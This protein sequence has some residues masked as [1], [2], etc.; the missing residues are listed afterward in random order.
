MNISKKD[1]LEWFKYLSSLSG[2]K[3]MVYTRFSMIIESTIRQIELAVNKKHSELKKEI[4]NLQTLKE[5]TFFV[6]KKSM[7]PK[8]CISCLFGNGLGGIRKTNR[9]N[10]TC[11]FCYYYDTLDEQE[12]IPDD[13]WEI[14]ENLYYEDDI[15]L[16]LSIQKNPKGVAYVYLE[17]FLEI[18][19]YYNIIKKF[20]KAGIYQHMYTNG[21]LCTEENLKKLGEAGLDELRFNL[22]AVNC[23][24]KV[25]E[26]M[27]IAKKYIAMVGI[28]TPMTN[29]FFEK[30]Q[31]KMDKIL[32]SGIDF[33]NCAELH[34]GQDN[35]NNYVGEKMY[36]SRR[37]YISPI[38]SRENTLKL[39]KIAES[40]KWNIVIH[41][42]SNHTKYCR[43]LNKASKQNQVFGST[44]YVSEFDRFLPHL[45]L[46]ILEDIDFKFIK[47]EKLP[48][49]LKLINCIDEIKS[50]IENDEEMY[51]DF[52]V[53]DNI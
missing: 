33:I 46:S 49:E 19:K 39:M 31:I 32:E 29:S 16:L 45:F 47:E 50:L 37:G 24:D 51:E 36:M 20:K 40:E 1:S 23:D 38:W 3:K 27:K 7:F 17:P 9:C 2:N 43:E 11:K 35:I 28:E 34:F 12:A 25:I 48:N 15:E 4:S 18:E 8:G 30:I 21:T 44:T 5:R 22:G 10:L 6:G 26:N 41:D 13:M 52:F 14:G 53:E 42:C